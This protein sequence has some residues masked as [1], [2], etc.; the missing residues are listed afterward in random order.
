MFVKKALRLRDKTNIRCWTDS[1]DTLAWIKGDSSLWKAFV[2]NR[3]VELQEVT[4]PANWD[5]VKGSDNPADLVTRGL[6]ANELMSSTLW[7]NGQLF[8]T[9]NIP[10]QFTDNSEIETVLLQNVVMLR[11]LWLYFYPLN[12]LENHV[13]RL[14]DGVRLTKL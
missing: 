4:D 10:Q 3:V 6:L 1:K 5:Y 2:A 7:L 14:N 13:L 9:A 8:I 11:N 12:K